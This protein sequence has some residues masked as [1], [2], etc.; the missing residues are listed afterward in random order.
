MKKKIMTFV[1]VLVIAACVVSS[2]ELWIWNVTL[3]KKVDDLTS[4][5]AIMEDEHQAVVDRADKC[6]EDTQ[7]FMHNCLSALAELETRYQDLYTIMNQQIENSDSDETG[8]TCGVPDSF[9]AILVTING[10]EYSV[11]GDF[12]TRT[13]LADILSSFS[14]IEMEDAISKYGYFIGEVEDTGKKIIITP[15]AW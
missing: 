7:E 2:V 14:I 13:E 10:L 6:Q 8:G 3:E 4:T 12:S 11:N 15:V 1:A 5:I 9:Q